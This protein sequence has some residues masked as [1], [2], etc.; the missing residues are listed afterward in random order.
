[1]CIAECAHLARAS[2]REELITILA[3]S[4]VSLAAALPSP[5]WYTTTTDHRAGTSYHAGVPVPDP[6]PVPV[7]VPV[8]VT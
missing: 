7:P 1:M 8:P 6:G 2:E 5:S 3:A 4:A